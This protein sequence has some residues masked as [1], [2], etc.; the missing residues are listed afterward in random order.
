[1]V[2]QKSTSS[3]NEMMLTLIVLKI[4]FKV[5][6]RALDQLELVIGNGG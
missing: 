1:M 4:T 3:S 5:Q 6:P 2:S